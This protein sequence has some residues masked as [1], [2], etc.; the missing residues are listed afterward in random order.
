MVSHD[1]WPALFRER[2]AWLSPRRRERLA[3]K[4]LVLAR[5]AVDEKGS[6]EASEDGPPSSARRPK[7]AAS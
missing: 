7:G 3:K 4:Y 2:R 1:V 5:A 6:G